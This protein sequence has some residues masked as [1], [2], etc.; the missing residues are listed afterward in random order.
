MSMLRG[1]QALDMAV[2][3]SAGASLFLTKAHSERTKKNLQNKLRDLEMGK[4]E[5]RWTRDCIEF[6]AALEK[7]RD[8]KVVRCELQ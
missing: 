4:V 6:K 5:R 7:L 8:R 3:D 1:G 2:F